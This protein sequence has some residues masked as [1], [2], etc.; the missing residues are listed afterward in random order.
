LL[1]PGTVA[2]DWTLYTANGKKMSLSQLKGRV[3]LLDFYFIGCTACM[4][5]IKPLKNLHEKYR[6]KNILIASVTKRDSKKAVLAFEKQYKIKYTGYVDA[7]NVVKSYH[8]EGF[9]T[10]Y[11]ID[12]E[13]KI[14]NA[15]VGFGD[16]FEEK[17]TSIIDMLLNKS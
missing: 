9:P 5:A 14:A 7:A 3:V 17:M 11:L 12:K 4:D 8:V 2:P 6:G 10:F 16:D 13:G 15:A 1:T